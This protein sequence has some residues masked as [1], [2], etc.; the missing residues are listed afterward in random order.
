MVVPGNDVEPPFG[1]ALLAL[2]RH[3]ASR[4]RPDAQGDPDRLAGGR[5][6]EVERGDDLVLKT[7]DIVVAD[8][9][10][11]LAQMR[12]DA[13]SP[14]QDGKVRGADRVGMRPAAGVPHRR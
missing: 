13:V 5:H 6:L 14:G 11:V 7:D 10:T 4:V 9:A 3:D 1:R 8:M 2:L 12:G